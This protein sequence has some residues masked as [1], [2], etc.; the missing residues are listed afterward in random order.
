[1]A[2]I[3]PKAPAA[4]QPTKPED[5][6]NEARLIPTTGIGGQADQEQRATSALLAVMRAVPEFGR[7]LLAQ[8]GAPA[9]RIRTYIEVE[10]PDDEGTAP[11]P[12]GAVIVEWGKKRWVALVE[13]KTGGAPLLTDQVNAYLDVAHSRGYDAV[14]TIS[15]DIMSS[16][17]ESPVKTKH[18]KAVALRHLSWWRILTEARVQHARHAISDPDQAWILAELIRYLES[19]RAGTGGFDDMGDRWVVVRDAA[20]QKTLRLA[21]AGVAQVASRWEQL[22]DFIALEFTKDLRRRVVPAWP[23]DLDAAG[24]LDRNVHSLVETG[25]L[26][27]SL[28]VPDAVGPLEM[29]ADLRARQVCTS[30]SLDAPQDGKPK[31]RLSWLL[32]QLADAP[33]GLRIEV[34]YPNVRDPERGL[35]RDVRKKPER[36]LLTADPRREPRSFRLLLCRDMG[37]KR[38]GVSGSFVSETQRQA[39][40]FYRSV[41]QTLR[42]WRAPAPT[43]PPPESDAVAEASGLAISKAAASVSDEAVAQNASVESSG[44]GDPN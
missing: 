18:W 1:M 2:Q 24:R 9:G 19:G 14:L 15:N 17:E 12:D 31:T 10:F 40:D 39:V 28:R 27:A 25:Q 6:W 35:L 16:P 26:H 38:S 41:V 34:H 44:E 21:D 23:K 3:K 22:I 8:A 36:L 7:A 43:L 5:L 29:E 32:R 30:V 42:P 33:E 13:V 37:M 20:H 4:K 11:R